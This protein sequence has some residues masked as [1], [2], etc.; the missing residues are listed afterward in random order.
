[1]RVDE[2]LTL[3]PRDLFSAIVASRPS[4]FRGFGALAVDNGSGRPG[5]ASASNPLSLA[6]H[7]IDALPRA[8]PAPL[9]EVVENSRGRRKVVGEVT[10]LDASPQDIENSVNDPAQ[11]VGLIASCGMAPFEK[12]FDESPLFIRQVARVRSNVHCSASAEA[13]PDT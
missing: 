1:L 7:A 6:E 8:V 4:R 2:H 9:A 5:S 3:T 10:P 13:N 11:A 12:R